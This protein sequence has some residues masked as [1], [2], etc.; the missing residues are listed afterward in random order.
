MP[1]GEFYVLLAFAVLGAMLVGAAGDLVMIFVGIELSSL[2]TYV[3]TA[4]AKRRVTVARRRAEVLPARHLRHRHP[5]LRHGLDL[6]SDRLDQ[7]RRDRRRH[8]RTASPARTYL[9]PSLLL[10]AA[11]GDRRSRLQD[12]GRAVPHLDAG[13]LRRRADP[14]DRLHVG[15]AEGG[16]LRRDDPHPGAGARPAAR[17]LGQCDRRAGAA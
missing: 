15:R 5:G 12:G 10:G 3:L 4:F 11:A 8:R 6:R 17:R 9:D 14:G 16:R 7:S 2:A 13:R 1:I